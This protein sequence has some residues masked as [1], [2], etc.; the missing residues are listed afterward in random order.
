MLLTSYS[1]E[2]PGNGV[3]SEELSGSGLFVDMSTGVILIV[4]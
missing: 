4:N 3:S 2:S 1:I